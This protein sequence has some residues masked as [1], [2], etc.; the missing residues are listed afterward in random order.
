MGTAG[1]D[2]VGVLIPSSPTV[3]GL[4][5]NAPPPPTNGAFVTPTSTLRFVDEPLCTGCGEGLR[6]DPVFTERWV[7]AVEDAVDCRERRRKCW[8]GSSRSSAASPEVVVSNPLAV[9][10]RAPAVG[11]MS[12]GRGRFEPEFPERIR[13][14][15]DSSL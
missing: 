4:I 8:S 6:E 15:D 11:T 12:I 10:D 1:D 3:L 2:P 13:L 7:D 14:L 5:T 9:P